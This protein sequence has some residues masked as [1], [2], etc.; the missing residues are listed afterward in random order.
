[1]ASEDSAK[2]KVCIPSSCVGYGGRVKGE[3]LGRVG[4]EVGKENSPDLSAC[5]EH[6]Q[7]RTG[8]QPAGSRGRNTGLRVGK[9]WTPAIV[10]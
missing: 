10:L 5:P 3:A 1:M 9:P 7:V 2:G 8:S 6:S 4:K